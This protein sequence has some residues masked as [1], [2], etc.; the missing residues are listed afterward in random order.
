MRLYLVI[1]GTILVF[2]DLRPP[3]GDVRAREGVLAEVQ[4]G[5]SAGSGPGE[6][7]TEWRI[8]IG[9]EDDV[10][11]KTLNAWGER[12]E[13][14]SRLLYELTE[15]QFR[16]AECSVEDK[17]SRG[18]IVIPK[19]LLGADL[20][21]GTEAMAQTHLGGTS[22]WRIHSVGVPD[23]RKG[24]L[25]G[26]G[27]VIAHE[28]GHAVFGLPDERDTK[29][30]H[31]IDC[32]RCI[33]GSDP[34]K[35]CGPT[36]H[37]GGIEHDCKTVIAGLYPG[38]V[39]FPNPKFKKGARPPKVKISIKD[40]SKKEDPPELTPFAKEEARRVQLWAAKGRAWDVRV[41]FQG[42]ASAAHFQRW[43]GYMI[44]MDRMLRRL[45]GGRYFMALCTLEDKAPDGWIVIEEGAEELSL[46]KSKADA[47]WGPQGDGWLTAGVIPPEG[48]A[49]YA[50]AQRLNLVEADPSCEGC[51]F[52]LRVWGEGVR[53]EV[54]DPKTHKGEGKSCMEALPEPL[55]LPP[56][57]SLRFKVVDR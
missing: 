26:L 14:A 48:L 40:R 12:M 10:D 8:S 5:R 52:N 51:V 6:V 34:Q 20:V 42:N 57:P 30:R 24:V 9:F 45:T 22:M 32:S 25:W 56:P 3:K 13:E 27:T 28:L 7:E 4:C 37:S 33:M 16:I 53:Y 15:G 41:S 49:R 18:R 31:G 35:L 29:D 54:C 17:T 2:A 19:G 44:Q 50:L 55:E 39:T 47:M 1:A 46:L 43:I 21:P 11:R 38:V 23:G 36:E